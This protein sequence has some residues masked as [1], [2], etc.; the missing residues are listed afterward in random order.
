MLLHF[1]SEQAYVITFPYKR[2]PSSIS[3]GMNYAAPAGV[4]LEVGSEQP[5]HRRI[6]GDS[7]HLCTS[8]DNDLRCERK[9]CG[10]GTTGGD[11]SDAFPSSEHRRAPSRG[12]EGGRARRMQEEQG[13]T[14]TGGRSLFKGRCPPLAPQSATGKVSRCAPKV[15]PYDTGA[16][17]RASYRLARG[18]RK[19]NHQTGGVQPPRGYAPLHFRNNQ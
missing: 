7:D 18:A 17:P 11:G 3:A 14:S 12:P 9:L 10:D 5:L 4:T 16:R 13:M 19:A 2:G 1:A 6:A 8:S 15:P